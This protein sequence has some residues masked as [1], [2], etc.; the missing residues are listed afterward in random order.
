MMQS[1]EYYKDNVPIVQVAEALGYEFNK[2]AGRNPLEY[3]HPDHNTIVISNPK[4]RQRYFT[5]HET[6][7]KGSVI[8]FVKHRLSQFQEYYTRESEG[9]GRSDPAVIVN[10]RLAGNR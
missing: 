4:G 10:G 3:K 9:S 7:N 5:R 8:D 1:F 6:E 2:K